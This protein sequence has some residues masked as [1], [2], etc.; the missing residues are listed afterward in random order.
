MVQIGGKGSQGL[1]KKIGLKDVV[2]KRQ[3]AALT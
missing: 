2:N 1:G 3:A